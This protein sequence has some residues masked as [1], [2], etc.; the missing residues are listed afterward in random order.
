M[1]SNGVKFT[2]P[3]TF[4]TEL[5]ARLSTSEK[6]E[7]FRY[8]EGLRNRTYMDQL[9]KLL[10]VTGLGEV[11]RIVLTLRNKRDVISAFSSGEPIRMVIMSNG[12]LI[13]L[14]RHRD[15]LNEDELR[16]MDEVYDLLNILI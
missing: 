11:A 16:I 12:L 1:E 13:A 2:D 7:S 15:E 6:M 14:K 8:F 10:Q 5:L 3:A 4:T 9:Q